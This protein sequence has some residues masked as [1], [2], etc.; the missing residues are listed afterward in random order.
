MKDLT[1]SKGRI[2]ID[3][4]NVFASLKTVQPKRCD[5][6]DHIFLISPGATATKDL[7]RHS[8]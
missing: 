8:L 2:S 6:A 4:Y 3:S 5:Q 1:Y 7:S